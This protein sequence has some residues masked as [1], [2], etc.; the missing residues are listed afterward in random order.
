VIIFDGAVVFVFCLLSGYP[1]FST[2]PIIIPTITHWQVDFSETGFRYWLFSTV[3][4]K[5]QIL[6][7]ENTAVSAAVLG[8]LLQ[9][10]IG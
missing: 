3:L 1:L 5:N 7:D 6:T 10:F 4:W 9:R 2:D 8:F